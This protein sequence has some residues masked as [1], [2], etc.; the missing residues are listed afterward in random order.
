M[1]GKKKDNLLV[2]FFETINNPNQEDAEENLLI[3]DK[4]KLFFKTFRYQSAQYKIVWSVRIFCWVLC[5]GVA[6]YGVI[7]ML[8]NIF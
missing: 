8:K 5:G 1:F 6:F 7:I 4:V 3:K 2:K